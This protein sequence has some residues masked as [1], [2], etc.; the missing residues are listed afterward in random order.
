M[1]FCGLY[2]KGI[3]LSCGSGLEEDKEV[4]KRKIE[5]QMRNLDY[6]IRDC[7]DFPCKFYE[8]HLFPYSEGFLKM[9]RL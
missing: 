1:I 3:C 7:P 5:E 4:V 2:I 8:E 9:I 6:C